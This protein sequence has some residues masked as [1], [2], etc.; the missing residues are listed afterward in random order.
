M[1]FIEYRRGTNTWSAYNVSFHRGLFDCRNHRFPISSL[2][3]S[4]RYAIL[5]WSPALLLYSPEFRQIYIKTEFVH[6]F[7]SCTV[8]LVKW[9]TGSTSF[10]FL[11]FPPPLLSLSISNLRDKFLSFENKFSPNRNEIRL[12]SRIV[13]CNCCFHRLYLHNCT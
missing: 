6:E 4:H 5:R 1:R 7:S 13:W 8:I 10:S 3:R 12:P 2:Q 11:L 9:V